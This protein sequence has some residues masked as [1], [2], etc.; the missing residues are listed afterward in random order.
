MAADENNETNE[1]PFTRPGFIVSAVVVAVVLVLGAILGTVGIVNATRD[2]PTAVP[3]TT[4][5]EG[6]SEEPSEPAEG[7]A[8]GASICGLK[9]EALEGTVE[10]APAAQWE[11]QGTI[12]Y[13]TSEEFGP[14]KTDENGVRSCFQHSPDGALFMAANAAAQGSDPETAEAWL[15]YA[16]ADGPVRDALLSES[17]GVTATEGVRLQVAGFRVLNYDGDTATVDLIIE[18]SAEG[19]EVTMSAVYSL[20]WEGGDWKLAADDAS[21]PVDFATITDTSG[22][23]M[24]GPNGG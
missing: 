14:G 22:Y 21:S 16:L 12:G 1:S 2:E 13:P 15:R 24:W 4:T 9:G 10:E 7:P 8:A 3:A 6:K 19:Q 20:V 23:V 11:F 18:G 17:E 5:S